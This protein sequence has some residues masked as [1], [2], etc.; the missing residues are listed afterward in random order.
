MIQQHFLQ[1]Q[2][3]NYNHDRLLERQSQALQ[4]RASEFRPFGTSSL[5]GRNY[6][7]YLEQIHGNNHRRDSLISQSRRNIGSSSETYRLMGDGASQMLPGNVNSV[8]QHSRHHSLPLVHAEKFEPVKVYDHPIF[9]PTPA[10]LRPVFHDT[11]HLDDNYNDKEDNKH[12]SDDDDDDHVRSSSPTNISLKNSNKIET[13]SITSN[14]HDHD[15]DH[16]DKD[17][18]DYA[19][20]GYISYK[21]W[22]E[23]YANIIPVN[24]L[25]YNIYTLRSNGSINSY[26][27]SLYSSLHRPRQLSGEEDLLTTTLS[28]LGSD[29][30]DIHHATSSSSHPRY[31]RLQ[32]HVRPK[33]PLPRSLPTIHTG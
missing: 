24:P 28:D 31:N 33:T 30:S 26:G 5:P 29:T 22:K 2:R 23:K 25:L 7:A 17:E 9:G 8:I 27:Q 16:D 13:S 6:E 15:H 18:S 32:S 14:K 20:L 3:L 11:N 1:Q 10:Y 12:E 21:R 4:P 19:P